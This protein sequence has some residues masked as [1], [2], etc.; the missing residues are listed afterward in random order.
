MTLCQY[1][2]PSLYSGFWL[3]ILHGAAVGLVRTSI[4]NPSSSVTILQLMMLL[5]RLLRS[6]QPRTAPD[7]T[8]F[9]RQLDKVEDDD[10]K[11]KELEFAPGSAQKVYYTTVKNG[12]CNAYI[13]ASAVSSN[14]VSTSKTGIMGRVSSI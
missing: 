4:E 10:M 13:A 9:S 1:P 8:W 6:L 7:L 12:L 3:P 2:L 5:R 14:M 11:A